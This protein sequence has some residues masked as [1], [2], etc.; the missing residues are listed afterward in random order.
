MGKISGNKTGF[1]QG[2]ESHKCTGITNFGAYSG[3][4]DMHCHFLANVTRPNSKAV[5]FP[6]KQ[7][8]FSRTLQDITA[9][10]KFYRGAYSPE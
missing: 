10:V 2:A 4:L 3:H 1:G 6:C 5:F 7:T 9:H 8:I